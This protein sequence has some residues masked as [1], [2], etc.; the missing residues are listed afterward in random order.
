M[1]IETCEGCAASAAYSAHVKS[2]AQC[3]KSMFSI[4]NNGLTRRS[5]TRCADGQALYTAAVAAKCTCP[6]DPSL[7]K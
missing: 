5:P 6:K 3:S 1:A 4:G 2:C 7:L